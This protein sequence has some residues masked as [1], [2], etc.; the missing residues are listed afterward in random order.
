ML[1]VSLW[2]PLPSPCSLKDAAEKREGV[3]GLEA[4]G[5]GYKSIMLVQEGR[6]NS[7]NHFYYSVLIRYKILIFLYTFYTLLEVNPTNRKH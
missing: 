2:S 6:T 5:G 3:T 1:L 7:E 4:G